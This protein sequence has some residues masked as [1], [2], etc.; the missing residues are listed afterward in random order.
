MNLMVAKEEELIKRFPLR[1]MTVGT[2]LDINPS[3]SCR[4]TSIWTEVAHKGSV[5][6]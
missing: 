4:D 3:I 5:S 6:K 1:T 2:N